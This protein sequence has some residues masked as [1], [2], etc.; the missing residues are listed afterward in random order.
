MSKGH[1]FLA[2]NSDVDYVRQACALALTIKKYNK[3]KKGIMSKK[4]KTR[5]R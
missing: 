1:I 3:H 5:R 2:Q 4:V